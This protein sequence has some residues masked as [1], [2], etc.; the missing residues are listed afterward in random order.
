MNIPIPNMVLSYSHFQFFFP[1]HFLQDP[2][3]SHL[4]LRNFLLL[5][6]NGSSV[7]SE[8]LFLWKKFSVAERKQSCSRG[9]VKE[10]NPS[11]EFSNPSIFSWIQDVIE[12]CQ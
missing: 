7:F 1:K 8:I 12:L 11:S 6:Q 10:D 3:F 2:S 4:S 5:S 9:T